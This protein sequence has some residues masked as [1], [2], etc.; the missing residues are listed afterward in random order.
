MVY[1]IEERKGLPTEGCREDPGLSALGRTKDSAMVVGLKPFM[2]RKGH[3]AIV[4]NLGIGDIVDS[5]EV[6]R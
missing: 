6:A 2:V 3:F 4:R 1:P 5:A